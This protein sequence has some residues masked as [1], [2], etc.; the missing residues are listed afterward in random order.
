MPANRTSSLVAREGLGGAYF[1][2][3]FRHA[4]TASEARPGQFVMIKAGVSAEPPLRRPFSILETSPERETFTLFVKA[5]GPGSKALAAL[6]IGD[7]AQC[8]GP[9]GHPFAA[10]PKDTEALMIGGG[11]GVAPFSFLGGELLR[12][13]RKARLFYGG[14]TTADLPL[15]ARLRAQ[16][17]DVVPATEDGTT[18]AEGR[19]TVPLEAHLDQGAG[20]SRLY[21]CGPEAMMHAVARIA[22]RRGLEAQVSLDPWMGCGV[23]TCLGCVVKIQRADDP[24]WKY[25]CACTEGPVFDAS[26]VVW[27]GDSVS[28]ASTL[29]KDEREA[30]P[31]E[32]R[33]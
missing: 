24:R 32:A 20:A 30:K 27:P 16:G 6:A 21:A 26:C 14:R 23:G 10:P 8:L 13:G 7:D 4:E 3:T 2:L 1:L 15:L 25:K 18:G 11:Y 9:L 12:D 22:A 29:R 17:L 33:P 31:S 28:H 5:I 19:V